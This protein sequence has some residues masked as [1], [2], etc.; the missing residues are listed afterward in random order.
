MPKKE[1]SNLPAEVGISDQQLRDIT[2]FEDAFAV[3]AEVHG[4]VLTA[5][6]EL[7]NGFALLDEEGKSKLVGIP[8]ML[9]EWN[10]VLGDYGAEFVTI[11]AIA[12]NEGIGIRKVIINDGS[13]GI[14]QQLQSYAD[15]T[16]RSGSLLVK[17][18]LRESSY[19]TYPKD[20]PVQ[21]LRNKPV[22]KGA[23]IPANAGK[24]STFYLDTSA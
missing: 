5:D 14:C 11:R 12:F 17:H 8:L 2:S 20:H 21:E 19:P 13:T 9:L 7:G 24:A 16:G 23:D 10:F 15:R 3:A 22:P 4:Q 1:S 6:E 18:G